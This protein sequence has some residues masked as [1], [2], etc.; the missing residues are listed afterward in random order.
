M[1]RNAGSQASINFINSKTENKEIET[2]F[3]RENEI[4]ANKYPFNDSLIE[5]CRQYVLGIG[6]EDRTY[7]SLNKVISNPNISKIYAIKHILEEGRFNDIKHALSQS[8]KEIAVIDIHEIDKIDYS[9]KTII[10][11]SG[12]SKSMIFR[13]L[14]KAKKDINKIFIL[15]TD[16][17]TLSP[18]VEN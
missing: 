11:V 14:I 7:E 16:A 12:L 2:F 17:K 13:L 10:D 4:T 8:N 15:E 3:I 5:A 18:S 1:I 9:I 6:F